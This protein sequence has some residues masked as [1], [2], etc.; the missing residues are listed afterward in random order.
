MKRIFGGVV[1]DF[2]AFE[3]AGS[4]VKFARVFDQRLEELARDIRHFRPVVGARVLLILDELPNPDHAAL[5]G[6]LGERLGRR[7]KPDHAIGHRGR[8]AE[9]AGERQK[10]AAVH[11][12][13]PWRSRPCPGCG[14]EHDP[15]CS[16]RMSS[17]TPIVLAFRR[18]PFR[19]PPA[20]S[21]RM[22]CQ[23]ANVQLWIWSGSRESDNLD[24]KLVMHP[25]TYE[26]RLTSAASSLEF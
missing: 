23:L 13:R 20:L 19:I 5:L 17:Q 4:K 7:G 18:L 6:L 21:K 3:Q 25:E 9:N 15:H 2:P 14:P 1:I 12:A 24:A 11:L 16:C 26:T 8:S 22:R 10:L